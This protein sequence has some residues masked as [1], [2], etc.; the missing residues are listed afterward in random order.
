LSDALSQQAAVVVALN[1]RLLVV[2]SS[3]QQLNA[4]QLIGNGP[5]LAVAPPATKRRASAGGKG[6]VG[7]RVANDGNA[8]V[9]AAT[10][11]TL[12]LSQ[13]QVLDAGDR[14]LGAVALVT[15]LAPRRRKVLRLRF[16]YPPTWPPEPISCWRSP[17][18]APPT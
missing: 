4:A 16:D 14:A 3:D 11:V 2:S 18:R 8:P 17:I 6:V 7:V 5:D 9:P 15:D 12:V 1:D 13:D 10:A